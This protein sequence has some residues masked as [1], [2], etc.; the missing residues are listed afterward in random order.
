MRG[1]LILGLVCAATAC[2]SFP[3][4]N[5]TLANSMASIRGA[6]EAGAAAVPKASLSLQLAREQ[7]GKAKA[8]L[9]DGKNEEA[10][11]MALRAIQD[12]ELANALAREEKARVEANK[13]EREVSAVAGE[14]GAKP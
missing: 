4:P 13:A 2:G 9:E 3:P 5:E 10:H 6:E 7:L 11:Y 14:S 8:L 1:K 12:A